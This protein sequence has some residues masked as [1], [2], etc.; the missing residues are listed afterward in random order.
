MTNK[1]IKL[2][3][4][5]LGEKRYKTIFEK[6][7]LI[8]VLDEGYSHSNTVKTRT[9][10][11]KQGQPVPWFT[12][13]AIEYLTQFDLKGKL[14]YEWGSG[15]SS[16]FFARKGCIVHSIEHDKDWV[17]EVQSKL[18]PNQHVYLK[19]PTVEDYVNSIESLNLKYDIILID[20]GLFRY[21]CA[22]IAS[23]YL[24]DGGM[25]ILDNSDW[26]KNSAKLLRNEDYIQIDFHGFGP[27]NYYTWT[28]SFFLSRNIRLNPV[29]DIQPSYSLGGIDHVCD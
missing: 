28:T 11:N 1:F 21:E 6:N 27:I 14:V 20:G 3:K 2:L 16:L 18:L 19:E 25:I 13:P 10:I 4:L 15:Y 17:E 22:Q 7:P 5:L 9:P 24:A 12:F 29:N 26:F 8:N 23:K